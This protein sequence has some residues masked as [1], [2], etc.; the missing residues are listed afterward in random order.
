MSE[1]D[2][3]SD[4]HGCY[5]QCM[6]CWAGAHSACENPACRCMTATQGVDERLTERMV[7]I[8]KTPQEAK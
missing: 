4:N 5:V 1:I 2:R 7:Q 8:N 3:E 6:L